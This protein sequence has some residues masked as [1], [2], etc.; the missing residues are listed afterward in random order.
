MYYNHFGLHQAPFK[1]TPN[2]EF[3]FS[4]GNRGPI[5]EA[6][7]YAIS[8]G[9]GIIKVT[10]EVGSGKTMLCNML[11]A[12]LPPNIETVYL[13]NP[14]VSPDEILHAIAFELQLGLDRNAS[15]LEAMQALQNHLLQRHADGKRVVVFVEESQGMPLATLEEIRLLSNLETKNDKL[16]QIVLF[17]QPE[18]DDNLQRP[19]IRQLRERIAHSF[20]LEPLNAG[21][22]REY[23]MFR[24][25]AAGYH[26]PDLFS[27]AVIKRMARASGGLTRR[28]NFIADKSLLAAFSEN[29][30]T[31]KPKHVA[32]A[33]RDSEFSSHTL[34]QSRPRYAWAIAFLAA[35][36]VLGAM[37][38]ALLERSGRI[39]LNAAALTAPATPATTPA[40]APSSEAVND[41][42]TDSYVTTP[43]PSS[44]RVNT[45]PGNT[46]SGTQTVAG[47]ATPPPE[48][49][50]NS[51]KP[52]ATAEADLV[53]QRFKATL[54]WLSNEPHNTFS[55]Q[56][57]GTN[58]EQQLKHHLN[59]I[60]K[61]VEM[62]KVFVY[63]TSVKQ[64]PS[65]TI[66]YGSFNSY[67]AAQEALEK[68][69]PFLKANRPILRT[70]Q[71][72]R[73][74]LKQRQ[75]T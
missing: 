25:R 59:E 37:L 11:P 41:I 34:R 4:G 17:G 29:T 65:I 13:A 51:G 31:I 53:H 6:L 21:E 15:R 9:E 73:T 56:L 68:L 43:A 36:A 57:M 58:D 22:I 19:D 60:G 38:Y 75:N 24:M 20:R 42:K 70:V 3:F 1:I 50:S 2:T 14:N 10:G 44:E 7:I 52:P 35:G 16:L 28:V 67:R 40:A 61:F 55:I 18:L 39:T 47:A 32:D 69:P 49:A 71:G 63:R 33:I 8:H 66:L 48:S 26:G 64:E 54:E 45:A 72:I 27:T 46:N 74:E 62:N 5:L 12:R 30:H 23:L